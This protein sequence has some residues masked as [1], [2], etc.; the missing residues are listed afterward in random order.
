MEEERNDVS[1]QA[2]DDTGSNVRITNAL[3]KKFRKAKKSSMYW[4]EVL[5]KSFCSP[6]LLCLGGHRVA[7]TDSLFNRITVVSIG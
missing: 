2:D 4:F 3:A 6:Y 7:F 1:Y 5:F